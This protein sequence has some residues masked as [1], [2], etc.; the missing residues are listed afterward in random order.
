MYIKSSK[1]YYRPCIITS[2]V[3]YVLLLI[4]K[5]NLLNLTFDPLLFSPMYQQP[6][7]PDVTPI[8]MTTVATK[9]I[10]R[11][12]A[13]AP[14]R[15]AV[16]APSIPQSIA[17]QPSPWQPVIPSSQPFAAMP[18]DRLPWEKPYEPQQP[19]K[20]AQSPVF[21]FRL[22]TSSLS[23]RVEELEHKRH[24]ICISCFLFFFFLSLHLF[25]Y[26]FFCLIAIAFIVF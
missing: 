16:S 12:P 15:P 13:A 4:A 18:T 5:L 11:S 20:P 2:N 17:Y 7:L 25:I 19:S 22:V 21:R 23:C 26:L 1:N 14:M 3:S 8:S 6:T 24:I 9:P 10:F